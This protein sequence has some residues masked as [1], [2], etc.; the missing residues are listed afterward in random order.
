MHAI[1][2]MERVQALLPEPYGESLDGRLMA[3]WRIGV[4]RGMFRLGWVLSE[5]AVHLEELFGLGVA[6][7]KIVV[8]ERP[9]VRNPVVMGHFF[10]I[11][12]PE[13]G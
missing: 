3:E 7:L 12:A 6:R 9:G 1:G 2:H 13:P 4:R 11:A 10:E 8:A 5:C